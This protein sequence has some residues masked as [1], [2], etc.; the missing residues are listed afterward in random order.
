MN[1]KVLTIIGL[2]VLVAI[3]ATGAY[4]YFTTSAGAT[5]TITA[6]TVNMKIASVVPSADCPAYADIDDTSVV[7][8]TDTNWAPGDSK[9]AKLCFTNTGSLAIPEVGF[10]WG[11]LSGP[12]ADHIF[13][14]SIM[15][16]GYGEQISNYLSMIDAN[17][18][19]KVA[20]S[21]LGAWNPGGEQEFFVYYGGIPVF[22]PVGT[23][24]SWVQY[25]LKF[26]ENAGNDLQ[27]ATFDFNLQLT[28]YQ[29]APY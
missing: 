18:D 8:W 11:G 28:G 13:I 29:H 6:G 22:L 10:K 17:S 3:L 14:T 2:V 1:K 23:D 26:D 4:A 15:V 25:T 24:V 5:G 20:L 27:G 12:L 19:G 9:T 21:E 7:L 16:S